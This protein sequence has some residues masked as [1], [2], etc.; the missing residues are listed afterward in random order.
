MGV[1]TSELGMNVLMH[2]CS[3]VISFAFGGL[4]IVGGREGLKTKTHSMI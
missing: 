4:E 3:D 2:D 1:S